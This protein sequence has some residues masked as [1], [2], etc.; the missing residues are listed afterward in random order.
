MGI[1]H[2][3]FLLILRPVVAGARLAPSASPGNAEAV[4]GL[5]NNRSAELG[6]QLPTT[7]QQASERAWRAFEHVLASDR[8][9]LPGPVQALL[10]SMPPNALAEDDAALRQD[11]LRE[12]R[13]AWQAGV[14]RGTIDIQKLLADARIWAEAAPDQQ[15]QRD[16][17]SQVLA[18]L[19][20][21]LRGK[22]YSRLARLLEDQDE[23]GTPL[24]V[25]AARHFLRRAAEHD[26]RL[27]A[28]L[29]WPAGEGPSEVQ[30]R[31][32]DM[33]GNLTETPPAPSETTEQTAGM[34]APANHTLDLSAEWPRLAPSAQ[35]LAQEVLAEL[36]RY[37]LEKRALLPGDLSAIRDEADRARLMQ[38]A[39]RF[40]AL[41][42]AE[43]QAPALVNGVGKLEALSGDL[44]TAQHDLQRAATLVTDLLTQAEAFANTYRV[45]LERRQW[46]AAL[47]ALKSAAARDPER[48][49]PFPL[50]Q[51]EPEAILHAD[52]FGATFLCRQRTSGNMVVV[53][54]VRR[55]VLDRDIADVFHDLQVLG[56]VE[57]AALPGL[58]D[59]GFADGEQTRAFVVRDH[60]EGLT[61]A[62]Q[63]AQHGP[64]TPADLLALARPIAEVL[65]AA[66]AR[67]I[68]CRSLQ[69]AHL[70]VRKEA[71][72]W[73]V[74]LLNIG[75]AVSRSVVRDLLN[76]PS[77]R[78]HTLLGAT[79]NN[80]LDYAAP[81][82]LGRQEGVALSAASD[83]YSLGRTCYFALLQT[84]EPDDQEKEAIPAGWRRLLGQCTAWRVER[85]PTSLG[86]LLE[87]PAAPAAEAPAARAEPTPALEPAPPRPAPED[88]LAFIQRGIA[89][90]QKGDANRAIAEFSRALQIDPRNAQ[91]Y[92][93][94]GNALS[95]KADFDRAIAD[96]SRA[97]EIDPHLSLAYVNRGLAF[98]KKKDSARAIADYTAAIKLDPKLALAYLNRGS[99]FAR[100]GDYD[101]AITDFTEALK[102]D[103][104]LTLAY[105]NR[106]LAHAKKGIFDRAIADYTKALEIDPNNREAKAR[107][108]EAVQARGRQAP[109]GARRRAR[110]PAAAPAGRSS[111]PAEPPREP[112]PGDALRVLEGHADAVRSVTFSPDGRR[113]VSGSEDKTIRVWDLK[114]GKKLARYMGHSG[115]VTCVAVSPS[116]EYILS[117][118]TD[119]SIRLW[120]M[121]SGEEVR[122]FGAGGRFFGGNAGHSDAVV[123]VAFAPDG[124]RAISAGW[125]KSVRLWDVET[126]KELRAIEGH[127]WLIHSVAFSPD[128]KHAV[129]GSE[130]Q[131][132]RMWDTTTGQEFRRFAGHGSWVL[133]VAFSPDGRQVLSGSSDGTM[134]LWSV[135]RGKELRRFGGQMGLV[136]SVAFSPDGRFVLS[137]EY[138]LP[139]E[140]TIMRLWE[141]ESGLEM[142]RFTGHKKLIWSVAFSPDGR[143][144]VS[145]SADQTLR[146]WRLPKG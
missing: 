115:A 124:A 106:G 144:A 116:G 62:E 126:G 55:E 125:D 29:P 145:G 42:E 28:A 127:N 107:R 64:L 112:A 40:H 13:A 51:Y 131:V 16:V 95:S 52:G 18:Q 8:Q 1:V 77:A 97:L 91:A 94:R 104:K 14:S 39:A 129:Y 136:Q 114:T 31:G 121:E 89:Y 11:C 54:D 80:T 70:L 63:V 23:Q 82:Q 90:R 15:S 142:A 93:G 96:Y 111:G 85:R 102:L 146:V 74:K 45:A 38:M 10:G 37:G 130:D 59:F 7:L 87:Q 20:D 3:L 100:R 119:H 81:E 84:P 30:Q 26:A 68:L 122:R 22:G 103:G 12:L 76:H 143:L 71:N 75:L 60:I 133:S 134:R 98:V 2:N 33:L 109:V 27:G 139:G 32:L 9:A 58:R 67:G 66:H 24:L 73:R 117:G 83:V 120:S 113:L 49:A 92:Q 69:P 4:I 5:L 43:R 140:N 50:A 35:L 123:S 135:A 61:L 47:T 99:A 25:I 78:S 65:Q 44:D 36:Q 132:V 105:V 79:V 6:Q 17:E 46:S 88:A 57:A 48:Y 141:V 86:V 21:A 19:T 110:T 72:G 34:A 108:A 56:A 138:T 41:P 128:G 101:R 137:G 53:Q 118:S